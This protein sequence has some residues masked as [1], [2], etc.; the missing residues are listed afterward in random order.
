MNK[1]NIDIVEQPEV[2]NNRPCY[3]PFMQCY[4]VE[5]KLGG[6]KYAR[7]FN[8]YT[9]GIEWLKSEFPQWFKKHFTVCSK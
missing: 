9:D 3:D 8:T 6:E 5:W 2:K 1:D 7:Y 4:K